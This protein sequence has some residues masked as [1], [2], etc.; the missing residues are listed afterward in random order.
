[1]KGVLSVAKRT[2]G[3]SLVLDV[4]NTPQATKELLERIGPVR[5]THFG[6]FYDV[7]ADLS[8]K[9]TAYTTEYL[10]PHN[11]STYF[12]EPVKLQSFHILSHTDGEGGATQLVDG[13][14]VV[15]QMN[16]EEK[17]ILR[18]VKLYAHS[19]GDEGV[20]V[21][22]EPF[23]VLEYD[24]NGLKR[25]RWNNNDRARFKAGALKSGIVEKWYKV[26]AKWEELIN[27]QDSRWWINFQLKPGMLL[28][29]LI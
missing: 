15:E 25:V 8:S 24:D 12:S 18:D 10:S 14:R 29:E 3:F 27:T 13:F 5:N 20:S 11:D 9:D 2:W 1:M 16:D 23:S 19:S 7:T 4:P 21:V 26:A 22:G 17:S 28:G 6:S